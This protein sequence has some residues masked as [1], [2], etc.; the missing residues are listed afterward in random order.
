MGEN[1]HPAAAALLRFFEYD[2]LPVTLQEVSGPFHELA[3]RV[4]N[5]PQGAETTT[6]L[7]KLL[8]AKDCAVRAALPQETT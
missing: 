2:H 4:A 8:E 7:R 3:H 1:V 6:C 5:G